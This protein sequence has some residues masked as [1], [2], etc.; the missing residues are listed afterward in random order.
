M[1]LAA[2]APFAASPTVIENV[3]HIRHKETDRLSAVAAELQRLGVR[4]DERADGM[5]IYP[6][7]RITPATIRTYD[8]HR[9]AMAF[10]LVGLRADGVVIAD[11]RCVA[12]TFPDYFE[13]LGALVA[14]S[15]LPHAE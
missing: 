4:V 1:T 9:M 12:K 6:A 7:S 11:P 13:R 15:P 3:A 2:V 14:G 8:D 5:T 10:A